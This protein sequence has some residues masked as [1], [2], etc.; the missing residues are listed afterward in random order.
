LYHRD[1]IEALRD[2]A[3]ERMGCVK[4][5]HTINNPSNKKTYEKTKSTPQEREDSPCEPLRTIYDRITEDCSCG[6]CCKTFSRPDRVPWVYRPDQRM[7]T[8]AK[9]GRIKI[10]ED[11]QFKSDLIDEHD[12]VRGYVYAPPSTMAE[13]KLAANIL[14]SQKQNDLNVQKE[15]ANNKK[16]A[17]D[18]RSKEI[19]YYE[20]EFKKYQK[21]IDQMEIKLS[22]LGNS[23]YKKNVE[24]EFQDQIGSY[25]FS[26]MSQVDKQFKL[27]I[28][29]DEQL[30]RDK[31]EY[32]N[33]IKSLKSA[34]AGVDRKIKQLQEL[35]YGQ[36]MSNNC[37]GNYTH[38]SKPPMIMNNQQSSSNDSSW[39]NN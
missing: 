16:K 21:Q 25:Q 14:E 20:G 15:L 27:E 31:I 5:I 10:E 30:K 36:R 18:M 8:N 33:K 35:P 37:A 1:G 24:K 6:K 17:F 11:C 34:L 12:E 29:F 2:F 19:S 38:Q 13:K 39:R 28:R 23:Q 32:T 7:M 26:V 3:E 22:N 4:Q 9:H